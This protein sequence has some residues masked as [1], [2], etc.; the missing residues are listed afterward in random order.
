M[1]RF[2]RT[3]KFSFGPAVP[4]AGIVIL[5]GLVNVVALLCTAGFPALYAQILTLQPLPTWTYYAYLAVY[6]LTY[7]FDDSLMV[8]IAVVTLSRRQL[9]ER[10]GR[11]L[12]LARGLVMAALGA[13]LLLRPEWLI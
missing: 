4:I 2:L 11:W 8:T 5:A 9:Q 7:S 1:G 12:K 10:A 13:V 6:H 3:P